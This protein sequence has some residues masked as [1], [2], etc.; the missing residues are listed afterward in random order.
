M[1]QALTNNLVDK[2]TGLNISTASYHT[3]ASTGGAGAVEATY[4]P[5]TRIHCK[6]DSGSA[7]IYSVTVKQV[8]AYTNMGVTIPDKTVTVQNGE[9]VELPVT[10]EENVT[11]LI[12]V[13][14]DQLAK[15]LFSYQE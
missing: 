9:E 2:D 6:N 14:C 13:E 1:A 4:K 15:I 3:F 8:T 11:N 5:N 12:T 10:P 7:A